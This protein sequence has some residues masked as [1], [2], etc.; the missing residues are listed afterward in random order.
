MVLFAGN[1]VWPYLSTLGALAKTRYT[2]RRYLY[3]PNYVS[4]MHTFASL[5]KSG[6]E[7]GFFSSVQCNDHFLLLISRGVGGLPRIWRRQCCSV[8]ITVLLLLVVLSIIMCWCAYY[9]LRWMLCISLQFLLMSAVKCNGTKDNIVPP[10][11]SPVSNVL[12][13]HETVRVMLPTRLMS[14]HLKLQHSRYRIL[15]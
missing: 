11:R 6:L 2:N 1:T 5:T 10:G 8:S 13:T 4:H 3:L 14:F 15:G 7:K 9:I 12:K